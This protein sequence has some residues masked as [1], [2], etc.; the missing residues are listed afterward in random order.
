MIDRSRFRLAGDPPPVALDN[1]RVRVSS[2]SCRCVR[3]CSTSP[4]SRPHGGR[5]VKTR[6]GGTTA[7]CDSP[8]ACTTK[9]CSRSCP[10]SEQPAEI[11]KSSRR[12]RRKCSHDCCS[13]SSSPRWCSGMVG[14][15]TARRPLSGHACCCRVGRTA[16]R[17]YALLLD[18]PFQGL[19]W[20]SSALMSGASGND[21]LRLLSATQRW[22]A[23]SN[24]ARLG[25][26]RRM[27][28][29]RA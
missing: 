12:R 26:F 21:L 22:A 23:A 7:S 27:C 28:C 11:L 9:P 18:V 13:A 15:Q 8:R 1:L 29:T 4:F 19:V 5:E 10:G 17:K 24:S 16:W 20:R 2:D 6:R 25:H 14:G 3:V